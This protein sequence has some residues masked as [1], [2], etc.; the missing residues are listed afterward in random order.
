MA[1]K[2]QMEAE[3]GQE[4]NMEAMLQKTETHITEK[5]YRIAH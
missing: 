4:T 2:A 5:K 3:E 1:I